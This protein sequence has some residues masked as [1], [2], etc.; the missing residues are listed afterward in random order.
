MISPV[1]IGGGWEDSRYIVH[2][3]PY[4]RRTIERRAEN[5][6]S[7][8]A[9]SVQIYPLKRR[10]LADT[11]R[12]WLYPS[13][14]KRIVDVV[15]LDGSI[16]RY[17]DYDGTMTRV[18]DGAQ[19]STVIL[20]DGAAPTLDRNVGGKA[21]RVAISDVTFVRRPWYTWIVV[22]LIVWFIAVYIPV[23]SLF[24][25]PGVECHGSVCRGLVQMGDKMYN[26]T[27][28][29]GRLVSIQETSWMPPWYA[30]PALTALVLTLAYIFI[31][32][33]VEVMSPKIDY[34]A[35]L[36]VGNAAFVVAPS[37]LARKSVRE[38]V[39]QLRGA[40]I[41]V[42]MR[43]LRE[44][45]Q[46]AYTTAHENLLLRN[47][48]VDAAV[49][50]RDVGRLREMAT[51][52][53]LKLAASKAAKMPPWIWLLITF[54]VGLALGFVLGGGIGV[55]PAGHT[56]TTTTTTAPMATGGP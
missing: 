31:V 43:S 48:S 56:T 49:R 2:S 8:D 32:I 14:P 45:Q 30:W 36:R 55:A 54:A 6:P 27:L 22:A 10:K 19:M 4:K 23:L 47:Q 51:I 12:W 5:T 39:Q 13:V 20:P 35:L 29:G 42:V 38:M 41:D 16:R 25:P 46:L 1:P 53:E 50:S 52:E 17:V 28:V 34:L 44:L 21:T 9:V 7:R 40:T 24:F 33:F 3:A 15:D 18:V 26:V 37:P 11:L